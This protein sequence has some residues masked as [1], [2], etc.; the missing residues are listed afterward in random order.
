MVVTLA[1]APAAFVISMSYATN[2]S[3]Q[4]GGFSTNISFDN[5]SS[6]NGTFRVCGQVISQCGNQ[7]GGTVGGM[8]NI[9]SSLLTGFPSPSY[10]GTAPYPV[11]W[12]AATDDSH[13]TT[14]VP[15]NW[16][17]PVTF[18]TGYLVYSQP[19]A[20]AS[21]FTYTNTTPATYQSTT[22][23]CDIDFVCPVSEG[24]YYSIQLLGC[25]KGYNSNVGIAPE[26]VFSGI[27]YYIPNTY[28]P[29]YSPGTLVT[30]SNSTGGGTQNVNLVSV[31]GSSL[32]HPA[33]PV[34][35]YTTLDT[36]IAAVEGTYLSSPQIPVDIV[37]VNGVVNGPMKSDIVAVEGVTLTT[38]VV[39]VSGGGGGGG[40]V[41]LASIGGTP[42]GYKNPLFV[43]GVY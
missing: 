42:V 32:A 13:T 43:A 25:V 36:N 27:L 38:P 28:G 3:A 37:E 19:F 2:P 10:S 14:S 31:A 17:S 26:V 15:N 20:T 5:T 7:G 33:L 30:V 18:P 1:G 22:P 12:V 8:V 21:T 39:P 6:A 23:P 40:D 35:S 41:N 16:F 29:F 24:F 11:N 4:D 34:S 9:I